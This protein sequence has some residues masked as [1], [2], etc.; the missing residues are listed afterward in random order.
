MLPTIRKTGGYMM[1]RPEETPAE[2]M[3]RA[4]LMAQETLARKDAVIAREREGRLHAEARVEAVE[5]KVAAVV[6]EN[7]ELKP[8]AERAEARTAELA[9]ENAA[10]A[11]PA[12]RRATP[13]DALDRASTT[14]DSA[15]Q[16][17]GG[18][19]SMQNRGGGYA[20]AGS[21]APPLATRK[22]G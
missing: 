2:V 14:H 1:S 18:H 21:A 6:A 3:A 16:R 10:Q 13:P 8:R 12:R 15:F 20:A 19:E 5:A 4:V 9:A 22:P 7:A 11:A 17:G